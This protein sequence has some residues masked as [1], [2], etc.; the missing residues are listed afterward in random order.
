VATVFSSL[1]LKLVATVSPVFASKSTVGLLVE[2]QNQSD[3][4]FPGLDLKTGSSS[5]VIWASKSPRRFFGLGIKPSRIQFVGCATK[6]TEGGRCG[7]R[8]E[9]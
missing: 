3:V 4:G 5:L 1:T 6:S 7:T 9:I 8:V 2:P